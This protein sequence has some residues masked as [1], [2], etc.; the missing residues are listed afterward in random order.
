MQKQT[1]GTHP[2]GVQYKATWE[3]SGATGAAPSL[4][5]EPS[6]TRWWTVLSAAAAVVENYD[7]FVKWSH[8]VAHTEKGAIKKV[9][10]KLHGQL[11]HPPT[12]AVIFFLNVLGVSFFNQH[13]A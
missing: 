10:Q 13:T 2:E 3:R 11:A 12:K 8:F 6:L 1:W 7:N 9:A 5:K 4:V